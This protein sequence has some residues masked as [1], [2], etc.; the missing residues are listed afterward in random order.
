MPLKKSAIPS[1][2]TDFRPIALLSFLSKVLEKIVH[3]QISDYLS[4]KKILVPLQS[5]F[6]QYHSTQ[7]TLIKLT[8]DIRTGIDS[9]KQLLTILLLF[10]FS[11]AFDTISPTKLLRKLIR[12]G[13]SRGVV[14]WIKSYI[15]G[16]NQKV[17]TKSSG[18]S[19]WLTTNL[20]VPQ[21][22]VLGPFLFSLYINDLQ[23]ILLDFNKNPQL[24]AVRHLL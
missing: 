1:A 20:G 10:D 13:F 14:L 2:V 17:I 24:S 12:M 19:D 15:T 18:T 3:D 7:T 23:D 21:G 8:D 9:Q 6:R 22:S 16:C 11:K 4:S 5:G